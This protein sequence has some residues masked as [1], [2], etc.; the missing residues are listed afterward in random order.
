MTNGAVQ[1]NAISY[2]GS[3][4]YYIA[5]KIYPNKGYNKVSRGYES[6]SKASL[7]TNTKVLT[8][9]DLSKLQL[10]LKHGTNT[11]LKNYIRAMG[12]WDCG[13]EHKNNNVIRRREY[14]SAFMPK[15]HFKVAHRPRSLEPQANI[16]I[17]II[18]LE[19]KNQLHSIDECTS[20]SGAGYISRKT[21]DVKIEVLRRIQHQRHGPPKF[22]MFDTEYDNA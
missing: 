21:M 6:Q 7:A 3:K 4:S 22:I 5:P 1:T 13:M 17:N 14:S 11:A 18:H 12:F 15:P 2:D 8:V 19:W 20:W 9:Q 16:S 10:R